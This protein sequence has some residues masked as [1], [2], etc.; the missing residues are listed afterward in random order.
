M[1]RA[2]GSTLLTRSRT[3]QTAQ[4][5]GTTAYMAPEYVKSGTCSPRVDAFA[6]GL[7]LVVTL[8]GLPAEQPVAGRTGEQHASLLDLYYDEVDEDADELLRRLQH[9]TGDAH[10]WDEL[11]PTVRELHTLASG[12]LEHRTKRRSEIRELIPQLEQCRKTAEACWTVPSEML[13]PISLQLMRQPV[14]AADGVTYE[15]REIER[16]LESSNR[17]PATGA[18]LAHNGLYPN[19]ALRDMIARCAP[20]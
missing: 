18:P 6:F 20:R 15:Q 7:T 13:C 1:R 8:T 14:V 5:A 4:V 10:E 17:S 19:L 2:G 16:W 3:W 9:T 11:A 12:C